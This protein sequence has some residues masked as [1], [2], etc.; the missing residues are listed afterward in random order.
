MAKIE[1][2]VEEQ[3]TKSAIVTSK[4]FNKYKDVLQVLL[5]DNEKY[6]ISEVEKILNNFLTREVK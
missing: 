1:K 6:S 4:K 2:R 5:K 3:F